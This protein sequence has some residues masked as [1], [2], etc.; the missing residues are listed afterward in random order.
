MLALVMALTRDY[1]KKCRPFPVGLPSELLITAGTR[2]HDPVHYKAHVFA[3]PLE[4]QN[5]IQ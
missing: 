1:S 5:K 2:A 4:I 3:E